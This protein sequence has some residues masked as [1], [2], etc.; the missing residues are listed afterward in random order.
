MINIMKVC[1]ISILFL[2]SFCNGFTVENAGMNPKK[3]PSSLVRH[4]GLLDDIS[5]MFL[6]SKDTKGKANSF[7]RNPY[8]KV[9]LPADF[10]LPEPKPLTL[11]NASDIPSLLKSSAALAIRLATSAFVLGWKIDTIFADPQDDSKYSLQIGPF[12]I[13]DSSSVLMNA[14]RPEKTLVLYEYDSSPYCKRV[15]EM[16]NLLDL[17]V[18]YRPCPGARNGKFSN[19][20]YEKTKRQTVPYLED[21]NTGVGMFESDDIIEYLL[22]TYGPQDKDLYD[23]KALWPITFKEFSIWTSTFAALFRG[24]PGSKRQTNAR[25]DNED[26]MPLE[27]WGYECSPFVKPVREK[28][29]ELV[30]PHRVESCSRGS[31][32]RIKLMARTGTKFQVPFLV[33]PNTGIEMF[34]SNEILKY[35]DAVY[36]SKEK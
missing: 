35:L 10:T 11:T 8:P 7:A 36:T 6:P 16:I 15:R 34:E 26:M 29:S 25:P 12:C 3:N 2:V 20:L 1:V 4:M 31:A 30:L 27:L 21:P 19:E 5:T 33:D 14:P 24:M 18:E 13:S 17:T 23:R 22:D 9:E 28:L 32:N